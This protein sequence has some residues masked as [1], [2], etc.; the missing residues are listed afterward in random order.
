M[1]P[2][3]PTVSN[4][5]AGSQNFQATSSGSSTVIVAPAAIAML[6]ISVLTISNGMFSTLAND[7]KFS[8]LCL[9]WDNWPKWSQK[10]VEVMEMS[11]MDDYLHGLI[12][13]PNAT[14]D[15]TSYRNWKGNN[16][17]VIGFLKA[18]VEDGE[19]NFL[20]TDNTQKAWENL[21]DRHK[22]QGP[23]TQVWL[24][25]E[26]LSI[27]YPKDMS[28]WSTTTDHIHNLCTCIF[29]QAVPTFNVLFMVAMLNTLECEADHIQSE[30]TSY[31]I[32]NVTATS[33]AL[34]N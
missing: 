14:T 33:S 16:K 2:T 29:S 4:T 13:Q 27:S 22:K 5:P 32:S 21:V 20:A 31:Y 19:K 18:Y 11:E 3:S 26:V 8:D 17:K 23:I 7:T 15:P 30:M 9:S 25:Q 28:T 34:S 1:A 24:I 12:P 6:S 10:I